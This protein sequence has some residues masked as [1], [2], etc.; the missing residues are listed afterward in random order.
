MSICDEG[1][2][3]A[4]KDRKRILAPFGRSADAEAQKIDGVG[5]GLTIVSELL[6]LQGG[7]LTIDSETGRGSVFTAVFPVA[8]GKP[9][10]FTQSAGSEEAEEKN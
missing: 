6:K 3:I 9:N 7:K 5:L 2:G 4:K 10:E 8:A 1:P